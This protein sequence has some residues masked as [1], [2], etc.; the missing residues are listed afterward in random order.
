METEASET[1]SEDLP[2]G[3]TDAETIAI[4]AQVSGSPKSGGSGQGGN[5]PANSKAARSRNSLR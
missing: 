4:D 1:V 3:A 5:R 2:N